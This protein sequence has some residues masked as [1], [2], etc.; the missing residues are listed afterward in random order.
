MTGSDLALVIA[1]LAI[2]ITVTAWHALQPRTGAHPS[3]AAGSANAGGSAARQSVQGDAR[4]QHELQQSAFGPGASRPTADL[5]VARPGRSATV[6]PAG[7]PLDA[8]CCAA[9]L[10]NHKHFIRSACG[11]AVLEGQLKG[12]GATGRSALRDSQA[13]PALA[14]DRP[15]HRPDMT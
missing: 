2:A 1:P 3:P 14:S 8:S 7:Q 4:Q 15:A 6:A 9:P 5:A 13:V 11:S 12:A 10:A